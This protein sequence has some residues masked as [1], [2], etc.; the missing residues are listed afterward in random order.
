M[1]S[2]GSELRDQCSIIFGLEKMSSLHLGH[3]YSP[4]AINKIFEQEL[5][6]ELSELDPEGGTV[7]RL[8]IAD[9][10]ICRD[11]ISDPE[12]WSQFPNEIVTRK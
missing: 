4:C 8:H 9:P 12:S 2:F 11:M 10:H 1:N 6:Q 3:I 7:T 5:E